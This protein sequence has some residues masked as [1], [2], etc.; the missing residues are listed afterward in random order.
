M[1]E[2]ESTINGDLFDPSR[3]RGYESQLNPTT[4]SNIYQG[5]PHN[6]ILVE[7]NIY[8]EAPEGRAHLNRDI[9][10]TKYF[11][12]PHIKRDIYETLPPPS[13]IKT[14]GNLNKAKTLINNI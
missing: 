3:N 11:E 10:P 1:F 2:P 8:P 5:D 6:E 14:M 13:Q 7:R 12:R 9:Y 4:A